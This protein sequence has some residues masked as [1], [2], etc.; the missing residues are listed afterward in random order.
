MLQHLLSLLIWLPMLLG[1]VVLGAGRLF[2]SDLIS[3]VLGM[4]SALIILGLCVP[5]YVHFDAK[6]PL[7]QFVE[8]KTWIAPLNINY[9]LGVDGISVL[10]ILLSAF[11]NLI[12]ILSAWNHLK[13]YVAEYIALFLFSTGILNGLF[14]AQ[15]AILFYVFW[16]ASMIPILLGIGIWGGVRRAYGA[17]KFFLIN[18]LC[19]LIM[20]A[21]LVYLYMLSGTFNLIELQNLVLPVSIQDYLF[22]AFFLAFA[23]KMPMWPLHT[24]FADLHAEAPAGGAIALA[25]LMLKTGA[26]GFLRFSLPITSGAHVGL[27]WFLVIMALIAVV[28]VGFAS[29]VQKE[30]KRLIAYSSISHMGITTLGIFMAMLLMRETGTTQFSN[31]ADAVLSMQ[32]AIFQMLAHAFASG[33]LFILVAVLASR[34]G[35][36]QIADYQGLAKTMPVLAFFFVIFCM[37]NVGL[38]GTSGFIGEFFVLLGA[39]QGNFWVAAIAA[40][41]LV[42]SPAYMLW[43]VKRVVFGEV[44]T[45]NKAIPGNLAAIEWIIMLLLAIPVLYFGIYPH[46]I[47]HLSYAASSHLVDLVARGAI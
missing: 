19:S 1:I 28:Y 47:L 22:V 8:L 15:D 10:F 32:G 23:V 4:I 12:I 13:E 16:E 2:R 25:T 29:I 34:F 26:Y 42:V 6:S 18:M 39:V 46:P 37:P 9:T 20:L 3:K 30:M 44:Q 45:T 24:W 33:G 40:L 27:V 21:G 36:S 35:S 7:L 5:L 38:P 14:A 17:I 43:L 11:T 41:T 31:H